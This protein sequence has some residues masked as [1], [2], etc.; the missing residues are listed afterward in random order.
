MRQTRS[1]TCALCGNDGECTTRTHTPACARR[2]IANICVDT[3]HLTHSARE[4]NTFVGSVH[5]V[6]EPTHSRAPTFVGVEG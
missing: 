3:F 5:L 4:A 1:P 6:V 2:A